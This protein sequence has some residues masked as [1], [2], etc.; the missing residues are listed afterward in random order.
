M[1][2]CVG[3]ICAPKGFLA[4]GIHSGIKKR[5]LDL[6][7]IY[8]PFL[9]NVV[10]FFS[11]NQIQ[12]APNIISKERVLKNKMACAILVNSGNA[13]C[14]VGKKGVSDVKELTALLAKRLN[15]EE[16]FILPASTGI[17][18][19]RLPLNRIKMAIPKLIN[20]LS[21]KGS[22]SAGKAIMTTD[23]IR[24]EI[25]VVF[26]VNKCSIKIGAIAK[27]AGMISPSL[28]TMLCFIS[29]DA[30][31]SYPAL[32]IAS[33]EAFDVSFNRITVD[34]QMSTNDM[35]VILANGLA[36][37]SI[38]L[39]NTKDFRLFKMALRYICEYLAKLIVKDAEGATKFIE[40]TVKN[41]LTELEASSIARGVANSPLVKTALYGED[42][43]FGRILSAIGACPSRFN[44]NRLKLFIQGLL[45]FK[46]GEIYYSNLNI[47][48]NRLK[49]DGINITI[50]LGIGK[51]TYRLW[52]SDLSEEYIRINSAY[53][54]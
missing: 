50:D 19:K 26:G 30:N 33:K 32:K 44:L 43:N 29:T 34:G 22:S 31:I 37:N 39:P 11:K 15:T 17:I 27:G 42:P 12:A 6:A 54:T 5:G 16:R 40:I 8:S 2:I 7:L 1:K 9:C 3:G 25:A 28:A 52:T 46:N 36:G 53:S 4:S 18:G 49:K 10:A 20:S 14:L 38:I 35:V 24:K 47:V 41:A 48:K 23:K 21:I 45:V 51:E 13:N